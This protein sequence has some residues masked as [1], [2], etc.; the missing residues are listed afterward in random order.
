MQLIKVLFAFICLFVSSYADTFGEDVEVEGLWRIDAAKQGANIEI[1]SSVGTRMALKFDK[2]GKVYKVNYKTLKPDSYPL[3]ESHSWE[4]IKDGIIHIAFKNKNSNI[5]G[6]FIFNN[7]F[8]NYLKIFKKTS[9]NCYQVILQNGHEQVHQWGAIMCKVT[10][11]VS[12]IFVKP[13]KS[14]NILIE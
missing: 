4:V 6:N 11:S 1:A 3:N 13:T 12:T 9:S 14:G 7:H 2:N 5:L 10:P 8:N